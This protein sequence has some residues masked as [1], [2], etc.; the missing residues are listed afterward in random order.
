[1]R[2]RNNWPPLWR[3][4]LCFYLWVT[5]QNFCQQLQQRRSYSVKCIIIP[6]TGLFWWSDIMH[7]FMPCRGKIMQVTYLCEEIIGKTWS[8]KWPPPLTK[9]YKNMHFSGTSL[10]LISAG[11]NRLVSASESQYKAQRGGGRGRLGW[12]F[13][14]FVSPGRKGRR[15]RGGFHINWV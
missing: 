6:F 14:I 10:Y 3:L 15:A 11:R 5:L 13:I 2:E 7:I 1:M 4:C 12:S 8:S 9:R